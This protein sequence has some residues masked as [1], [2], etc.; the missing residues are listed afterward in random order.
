MSVIPLQGIKN[1]IV[2]T[3]SFTYYLKKPYLIDF[4]VKAHGAS[5]APS[6]ENPSL[7]CSHIVLH[8]FNLGLADMKYP[9]I[10]WEIFFMTH[11]C[12]SLV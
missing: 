10:H 11:K 5:I 9:R 3:I 2:K 4:P 7:C 12:R 8:G 1:L 6:K